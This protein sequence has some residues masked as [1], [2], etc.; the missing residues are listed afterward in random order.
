[1]A[2]LEGINLIIGSLAIL[3]GVLMFW[4]LPV[5]KS[6]KADSTVLPLISIIIPARNEAQRIKPLL[7]SLQRQNV[8]S[9]ELLV[10]DDDSSDDTAVISREYGAHVIQNDTEKAGAGKSLACWQGAEHSNGKWL[11]FLDADTYFTKDNS[12]EK[13]L[14]FFQGKGNR[15]LL[16]LQPFHTVFNL[17]ENLSAVFNIIVIVGMNL[18]TVWKGK[19]KTAGAFGPCILVN[20]EDYFLTGG[21]KEIQDALMDD[22]AIGEAFIAKNLPVHCLGGKGTISFRMYPEGFKSMFE[23]WCKSFAIGSKSTHQLVMFMVIIWISGSF[24]IASEL[25]MS[26]IT[27]DPTSIIISSI[28]YTLFALQTALFARRTGNFKWYIFIFYP[29]LFIFF[30]VV[31][32]YSLFS[33][34]V[35]GS[36][37]W[38]GRKI[39]V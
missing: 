14:L 36:V 3:I 24:I 9:F 12:L 10:V 35:L 2:I 23:G 20:R 26:L 31:F 6:T 32:L 5:P 25:I 39:D 30:T 16:S 28:F 17:Y 21:H 1:M 7:Q 4:S 19:F 33:V 13:L 22:L 38:K 29:V 27:V 8:Q 11:L 18:F 34:H 15:G 37:T